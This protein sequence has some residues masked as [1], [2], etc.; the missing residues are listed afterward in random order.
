MSRQESKVY[1]GLLFKT[2]TI[3]RGT[4]SKMKKEGPQMDTDFSDFLFY[5]CPSV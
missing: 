5:L 3:N 2:A 1:F 4:P